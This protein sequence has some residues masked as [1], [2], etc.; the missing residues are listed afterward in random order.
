MEE[1]RVLINSG[2]RLDNF[3]GGRKMSVKRLG[4]FLVLV[5][6]AAGTLFAQRGTSVMA[7]DVILYVYN[8]GGKGHSLRLENTTNNTV[9]VKVS[10][11]VKYTDGRVTDVV[12]R[13][14]VLG[15]KKKVMVLNTGHSS[16]SNLRIE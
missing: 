11:T 7:K 2:L 4:I 3:L 1:Y 16:I 8:E 13:P 9:S 15:P 6:V 12:D 10:F 5:L 14:Y